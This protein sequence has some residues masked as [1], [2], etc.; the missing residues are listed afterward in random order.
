MFNFSFECDI[1]KKIETE[2]TTNLL[3]QKNENKLQNK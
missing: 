3:R 2:L 1:H